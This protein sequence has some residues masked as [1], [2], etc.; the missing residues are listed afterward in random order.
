MQGV[1]TKM[2]EQLNVMQEELTLK[3]QA[4]ERLT[5]AVNEVNTKVTKSEKSTEVNSHRLGACGYG[6]Y[7]GNHCVDSLL[8]NV[9]RL[10]R[11]AAS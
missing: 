9:Y 8:L 5:S 2:E 1:L 3:D 6:Q 10:Y 11:R 4:L 7:D